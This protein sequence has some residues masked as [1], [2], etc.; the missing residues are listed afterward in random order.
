[1][2]RGIEFESSETASILSFG[3]NQKVTAKIDGYLL[4]LSLSYSNSN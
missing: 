1:M 2:Y 3:V 4:R